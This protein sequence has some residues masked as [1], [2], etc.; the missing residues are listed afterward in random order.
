MAR[1]VGTKSGAEAG[2]D[3]RSSA[4]AFAALAGL[5]VLA[6]AV[7]APARAADAPA[8]SEILAPGPH[9]VGHW[10]G[11]PTSPCVLE[12]DE[13][14]RTIPV[15][16]WYPA[17][18]HP[19]SARPLANQQ[20][21]EPVIGAE[22]YPLILYSHGF[23]STS[24]EGTSL[25]SHLASHGYVVM[26]PEFPFTHLFTPG[27]LDLFDVIN[28]HGDVSFL[29]DVMLE[30]SQLPG[31]PF[32]AAV[33]PERIGIAG[34][35]LGGMTTLLTAFHSQLRD[36]RVKVAVP[37]A[38]PGDFFGE[39]FYDH[40]EVPLMIM[41]S[42]RDALV[43]YTHSAVTSFERANSPRTFVT[44][45]GGSHTGWAHY[46]PLYMEGMHNPDS[47]GCGAIAGEIPADMSDS[48]FLEVLG[49]EA[50]GIVSPT[51]PLPCQG[52][53]AELVEIES[54]RPS[55]QH[56][57]T[58]LAVRPFLDLHLS[59]DESRRA[60]AEAFLSGPLMDENPEL[61]V[62]RDDA[63]CVPEPSQA[64][65]AAAALG[66]LAALRRGRRPAISRR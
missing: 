31:H 5:C 58:I 18:P 52:E 22:P 54:M 46:A 28:Q 15:E 1:A 45:V 65:L 12:D 57:L 43:S 34:L 14:L 20:E 7:A 9:G 40:A 61:Q 36:P 26:A 23:S 59:R 2:R 32:E 64:L 42:D 35:S 25:N 16:I 10:G 30:W 29:I 13:R 62:C 21:A 27:G 60:S 55:R 4:T 66:T 50:E 44:L 63:V 53:L 38:A 33:D 17:A 6:V 56:E 41:A 49:G 47:V 11:K 24:N 51:S 48:D 37:I 3:R 8:S 19:D 39:S